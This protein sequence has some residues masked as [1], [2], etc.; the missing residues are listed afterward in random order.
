M[1]NEKYE[2]I[3]KLYNENEGVTWNM[4]VLWLMENGYNDMAEMTDEDIMKA[5]CPNMFADDFFRNILK[6]TRQLAKETSP[7]DLLMYTMVNPFMNL[8]NFHN[9]PSRN[10]LEEMIKNC[11]DKDVYSKMRVEDVE[12][13]CD[14]FCCDAEE[15]EKLGYEIP[16]AYWE[17]ED[18]R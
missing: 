8:M 18:Y 11:I 3:N 2:L 16:E 17:K 4:A 13:F 6:L 12:N 10:R 5:E 1:S 14:M 7:Y 15:L 9:V